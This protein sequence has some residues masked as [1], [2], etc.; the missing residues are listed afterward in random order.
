MKGDELLKAL[1]NQF[2]ETGKVDICD[3]A[4]YLAEVNKTNSKTEALAILD[5]LGIQYIDKEKE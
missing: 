2:N 5:D 3:M 4:D 1:S